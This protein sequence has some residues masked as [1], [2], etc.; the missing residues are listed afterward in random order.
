MISGT[1]FRIDRASSNMPAV[2]AAVAV[3]RAAYAAPA[4]DPTAWKHA[5]INLTAEQ[6][7]RSPE[8]R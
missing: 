1:L 7:R 6:R 5:P 3:H 4:T 8:T 2:A